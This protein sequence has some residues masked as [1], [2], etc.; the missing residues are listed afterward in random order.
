MHF[1]SIRAP[2][3]ALL[4]ITLLIAAHAVVRVTEA[5]APCN[6]SANRGAG[7]RSRQAI[8]PKDLPPL[9]HPALPNTGDPDLDRKYQQQQEKLFAKQARE[10]QK[11][12]RRQEHDHRRLERQNADE[13]ER[14]QVEQWHQQQTE[15]LQQ[16]HLQQQQQ[17]EMQQMPRQRQLTVSSVAGLH[18]RLEFALCSGLP[19]ALGEWKQQP[20]EQLT[21]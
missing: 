14:Q 12:Q 5:G 21:V 3:F 6:P 19:S 18:P 11:L 20:P 8:H 7:G 15:R 16:R 4:V 17:L 1:A 13:V 9:E 10:R 2:V